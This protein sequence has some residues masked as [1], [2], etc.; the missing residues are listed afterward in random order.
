MITIKF[1]YEITVE[2]KNTVSSTFKI[3]DE[4]D[5]AYELAKDFYNNCYKHI[6]RED[7]YLVHT[8]LINL[9]G[10]NIYIP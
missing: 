8:K 3:A 5:K 2:S 1:Y 4:F 10:S 7:I 6:K 9:S